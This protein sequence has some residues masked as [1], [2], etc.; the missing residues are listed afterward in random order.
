MVT[1][2]DQYR[3]VFEA[4]LSA[5][6][7]TTVGFEFSD[8]GAQPVFGDLYSVGTRQKIALQ[9][10]TFD[11]FVEQIATVSRAAG[12]AMVPPAAVAISNLKKFL[13]QPTPNNGLAFAGFS[14]VDGQTGTETKPITKTV[15]AT[16]LLKTKR[17]LGYWPEG[18]LS[19]SGLSAAAYARRAL[20][21]MRRYYTDR[22]GKQ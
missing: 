2:F 14:F 4:A 20:R 12:R 3:H 10:A 11:S 16:D 13:S 22:T 19:T 6:H 9:H 1:F 7:P 15:R 18:T 8:D 17:D 5:D 21:C